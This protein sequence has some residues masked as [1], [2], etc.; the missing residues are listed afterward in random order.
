MSHLKHA[1]ILVAAVVVIGCQ[2]AGDT[3]TTPA[4]P[5]AAPAGDAGHG[6][7]HTPEFTVVAEDH[8]FGPNELRVS[9]GDRVTVILDNRGQS[10][11]NIAFDLPGDMV[12][13]AENV[14]AGGS[15]TLAF[16]APTEGTYTFFCPVG[17]H[18]EMGMVGTLIVGPA[19]AH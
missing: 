8:R 2:P 11:H 4:T 17:N 12:T 10:P 5:V 9:A 14:P 16:V 7:T 3:G 19:H 15:D 18:R 1:W 13:L 6:H